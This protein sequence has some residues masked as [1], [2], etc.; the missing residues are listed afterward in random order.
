MQIFNVYKLSNP[1]YM[2][3]KEVLSGQKVSDIINESN[4]DKVYLLVDHEM[5][6]IWT[7]N[8]LKSAFKT[9]V[10]GGILANLLRRQLRLFYKIYSLNAH[11]RDEKIFQE[12]MDKTLAPGRAKEIEKEEFPKYSDQN[13]ASETLSLHQG[14][15]TNKA[16]E[17]LEDLPKINNFDKKFVIV[18]SN[19]YTEEKVLEKFISEEKIVS[20]YKNIGQLNNGFNFFGD[21]N[22]S[23]R[24]VIKDR[25]LQ[26][27]ELYIDREQKSEPLKLSIPV[28]KDEEFTK[29]RDIENLTKAFQIPEKNPEEG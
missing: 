17:Y 9:Q 27:I 7:Y 2:G 5:K 21:K 22:Y 26:G 10:Y 3:I 23:T 20:S 19:I 28:F 15:N 6:R 25:N 12:L 14:L 11:S 16:M 1:P 18:G 13:L 29:S 24:L 4:E 8:G